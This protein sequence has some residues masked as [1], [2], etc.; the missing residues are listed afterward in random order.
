MGQCGPMRGAN[1]WLEV[2]VRR[3]GLIF[4]GGLTL[5]SLAAWIWLLLGAGMEMT[6]I[7]MT[8]MA[9]MNGW[10]MQKAD[11][12][13]AYTALMFSMWWVMMIAMMMPSA[14]PMLLTVMQMMA[15]RPDAQDSAVYAGIFASG[16][17]VMWGLY[18]IAA[19]GLQWSFERATL[20]SPMLEVTNV[21]L[22]AAILIAAGGWQF[23]NLKARCLHHC[24]N[25]I[26]YL[27]A[28]WRTGRWG[29]FR[30]GLGHGAYCLGCCWFLMAL[31]FFGGVM[32]LYWI[33]GL[34]VFVILEKTVPFGHWLGK[35]VG[36]SLIGSGAALL[37]L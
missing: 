37:M 14:A 25:P 31:L 6:A 35:V 24:R 7:E 36:A 11:W 33:A 21:W 8:Q 32:N 16:Y 29:A 3:D 19:T 26:L 4:V 5:V 10:L 30:M 17:L 13:L 20:M 34:T 28:K 18:S 2:A 1:A 27:I 9:G 12:T 22:G 23:T 15:K